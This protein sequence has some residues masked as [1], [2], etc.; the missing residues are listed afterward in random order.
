MWGLWCSFIHTNAY[1]DILGRSIRFRLISTL[2]WPA[3]C[4]SFRFLLFSFLI[5]LVLLCCF[6][7][8]FL[9]RIICALL[10]LC[11]IHYFSM[12]LPF[13]SLPFP[14]RVFSSLLFKMYFLCFLLSCYFF[15]IFVLLSC[16]SPLHEMYFLLFLLSCSFLFTSFSSSAV[17]SFFKMYFLFF[18]LSCSFFS[19]FLLLSCCSFLY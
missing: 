10:L 7:C 19:I 2:L 4:P 14:F 13:C 12:F 1:E 15:S 18:L 5:R 16:C 3:L 8:M 17:Y 9:P 11:P 6:I